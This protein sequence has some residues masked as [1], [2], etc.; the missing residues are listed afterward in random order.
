MIDEA[1]LRKLELW[2]DGDRLALQQFLTDNGLRYEDDIDAA[3]GLFDGD[4]RLLGCGCAAGK[5]LKCF[6]LDVSLRGQNALGTLVS[7]LMQDRFDKGLS[8]LMVITR[9]Q[10]EA[11][12]TGC[13]LFPLARTETLVLLENRADGPERFCRPLLRSEDSGKTVGAIVMNAN[14]FTKGHEYLVR[15]A[16]RSCDVLHLFVVEEDR[17]MFPSAVR[18]NLVE[19]CVGDL[20]NVRI[21][22]SGSYMISAATFPTYFLKDGENAA[23]LQS[24]LDITLFAERIAPNL[25]I[26][27]RFAGSEPKDATTAIYNEAMRTILPRCGIAFRELLRLE[28]GGDAVS[29]GRVRKCMEWQDWE[30]LAALVPE[31]TLQ[32]LRGEWKRG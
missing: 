7:A 6:A 29:A 31:T 14:P 18:R 19:R 5:L 12:F 27:V 32:Y 25:N 10:N 3:F 26:S 9:R 17:S 2:D 11:Y 23:R 21:H 24:E 8:D 20:A 28:V 30:Q 22:L 13:G 4:E 16:S 15:Q 1:T